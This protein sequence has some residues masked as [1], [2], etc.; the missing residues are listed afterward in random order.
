M[1]NLTNRTI[2]CIKGSKNIRNRN[3]YEYYDIL[4]VK[5]VYSLLR[6]I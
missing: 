1:E 5:F 4:G 3:D 6:V 2:N